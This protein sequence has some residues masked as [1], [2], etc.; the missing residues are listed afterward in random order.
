M[1]DGEINCWV[2]KLL[3]E[4]ITPTT[5][6]DGMG[7]HPLDILQK[8][9][10]GTRRNRKGIVRD[11]IPSPRIQTAAEPSEAGIHLRLSR[12]SG[13]AG[14]VNFEGGIRCVPKILLDDNAERMF[15]N[16]MAF[17]RLQ[18]G[19]GNDV[20]LFVAFMDELTNTPKDV[21][22]LWSK[23]IIKNGLGNDE[24]VANL[25]NNTLTKGAVMDPDSSL[26]NV[27]KEVDAYCKKPWNSWRASL[28]HT[29]F[30]NPWVFI[31]L[32]AATTLVFTAL[33][34]TV[35]A[36]LSFKKKS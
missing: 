5:P 9:I 11:P 26:H 17:E 22:L 12:G 13:F 23:G 16:L 32:V 6:I 2:I 15:L 35:Y 25:I 1:Q 18:P 4:T 36:A 27:V 24:A 28:I 8:S 33:I 31:S 20:N 19:A 21:R 14:T 29:Y 30:S 34:Q 7:L 10:S 3:S